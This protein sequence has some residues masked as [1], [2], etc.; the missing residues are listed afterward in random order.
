M[1]FPLLLFVVVFEEEDRTATSLEDGE[2]LV[3]V[4]E[5]VASNVVSFMVR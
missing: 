1:A 5:F 3:V 4:D 2:V